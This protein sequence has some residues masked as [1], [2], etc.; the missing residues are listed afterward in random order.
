MESVAQRCGPR[1]DAQAVPGWPDRHHSQA[2]VT[3]H[4]H[5]VLYTVDLATGREREAVKAIGAF[6]PLGIALDGVHGLVYAGTWEGQL[7]WF[8]LRVLQSPELIEIT[9]RV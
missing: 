8:P 1:P 4:A 2:Y 7:W 5:D 6:S 9:T 3:D